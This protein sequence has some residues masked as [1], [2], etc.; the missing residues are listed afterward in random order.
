MALEKIIRISGT[1]VPFLQDDVDTDQIIPGRFL[2]CVTFEGLG[3]HLFHDLRFDAQGRPK[4]H[5]L[6][7]PVYRGADILVSGRN[8]GCG[9]SREHAPQALKKF[10]IRAVAAGGFAEIFFGN[11][12]AIGVPCVSLAAED[13]E[14]LA[15][16]VRRDPKLNVVVDLAERRVRFGGVNAELRISEAARRSLMAGQWDAIGVL[17]EA[18][19]AVAGLEAALPG[20]R[21]GGATWLAHAAPVSGGE[22][23]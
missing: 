9:S 19:D 2:R 16:A 20:P 14:K 6:D 1:A 11:A 7:L 10:G 21:A 12:T 15:Q 3:A 4:G 23:L 13:L 18:R 5:P 17:L 8:F 22:L